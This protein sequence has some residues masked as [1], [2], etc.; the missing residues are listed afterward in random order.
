MDSD[1]DENKAEIMQRIQ[2]CL[3][4]DL[5]REERVRE[6]ERERGEEDNNPETERRDNA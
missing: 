2:K 3:K 1:G 6:R 5:S 4:M